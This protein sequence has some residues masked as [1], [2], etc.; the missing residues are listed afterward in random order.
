MTSTLDCWTPANGNFKVC[1]I[2][3]LYGVTVTT[4]VTDVNHRR[5]PLIQG[6]LKLPVGVT[7]TMESTEKNNVH[8]L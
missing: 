5:L 7:V 6:G 3:I 1:R 4:K 8:S 2:I